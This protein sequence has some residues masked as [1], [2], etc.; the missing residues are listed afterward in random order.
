MATPDNF[1]YPIDTAPD[2]SNSAKIILLTGINGY[3]A[4]HIALLL[5]RK[6]YTV[7][8]TSRS[9]NTVGRLLSQTAFAPYATHSPARVQHVVV[10][11]MTQPGA[12]DEA[13]RGVHAVIHTASPVDFTLTSVDAFFAPAVGGVVS[14]LTAAIAENARGGHIVSFVQLSSI[15]AVVDMWRHP[16][17]SAGGRENRAYTEADWNVRGEAVARDSEAAARDGRGKWLPMVAYGASK[18]A[19]ERAMWDFVRQ[20]DVQGEPGRGQDMACAA[21]NPGV[22]TG[23]PVNWPDSPER[24]NETLLPVWDIWSGKS[25]Q[26]NTLPPLIG[27]NTYIDV[28][29]VAALHVWVMEH[30]DQARGQRYLATN[31]KAPPQAIAD[32]LRRD[33]EK[34]LFPGQEGRKVRERIIVG[35]PGKGYVEG[36]GWPSDEPSCV[37]RKAYQS[38]AVERFR[39]YEESIRDTVLAFRL[40][41]PEWGL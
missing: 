36:F 13:V 8:G 12:F 21:I 39:G 29:D 14:L 27:G 16:P 32:L 22:V 37:A 23:P 4:S 5:L 7:R 6:G 11:D 34:G 26:T 3:I 30:P 15:A 17:V 1:S 33:D 20:R 40:Q 10:T 2:A 25:K 24:L 31:G 19:A 35:E 41:W 9:A 18:A 38:L 28:R